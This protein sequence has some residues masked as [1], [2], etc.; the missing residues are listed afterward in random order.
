MALLTAG[1]IGFVIGFLVGAISAVT[2]M[3]AQRGPY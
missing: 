1:I 3:E 2:W